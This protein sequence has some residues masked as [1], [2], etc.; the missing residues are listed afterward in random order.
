M[1]S[2]I[3]YNIVDLASMLFNIHFTIS[4]KLNLNAWGHT[5]RWLL[6]RL[7]GD[8][9]DI[10]STGDVVVEYTAVCFT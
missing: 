4:L 6:I 7:L 3:H 2:G 10:C 8:W 1:Y 9:D 5:S